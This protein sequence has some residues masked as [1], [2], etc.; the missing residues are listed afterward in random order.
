MNFA[1]NVYFCLLED[2]FASTSGETLKETGASN[3]APVPFYLSIK[4]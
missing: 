3:E 1:Q 2:F 4:N